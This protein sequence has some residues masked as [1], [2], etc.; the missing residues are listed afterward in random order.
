MKQGY[1]GNCWFVA[2]VCCLAEKQELLERIFGENKISPI[3]K[4]KLN[5]FKNGQP[6]SVKIDS[7]I[8]VGDKSNACFGSSSNLNQMWVPLL[9]KAYSKLNGS[10][11]SLTSGECH[12]AF[13]DMTGCPSGLLEAPKIEFQ[14]L[15]QKFRDG[16]YLMTAGINSKK[17]GHG[18]F[19][20]MSQGLLIDHAY[21]II[22]VREHTETG[23][24]PVRLVKLRNPWS[25][26]E[27]NGDYSDHSSKWDPKLRKDLH[28]CA[29][30]NDGVFWMD[31]GH[32]RSI[33]DTFSF[34]DSRHE[35]RSIPKSFSFNLQNERVESPRFSFKV[36][37][38]MVLK[39]LSLHQND[40]R[41][42][43][44]PQNYID[45][46]GFVLKNGEGYFEDQK[47]VGLLESN[48]DRNTFSKFK[49]QTGEYTF[50][51]YSSGSHFGGQNLRDV[52]VLLHLTPEKSDKIRLKT[53]NG[54]LKTE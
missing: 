19:K 27:W 35:W 31:F 18:Y 29:D 17:P 7:L 46:A 48:I 54:D 24:E 26:F 12:E 15:Q 8:P 43:S 1:F 16:G 11:K 13:F 53:E 41:I 50:V 52:T 32:F 2:A 23:R 25:R 20:M 28:L 22:D 49:L 45:L 10:Y 38:K 51:P 5:L 47:C 40:K 3:G 36:P 9:E 34:C 30:D 42:K 37:G 21:A 44:S 4:Y 39:Y 14:W 6:V 33:F